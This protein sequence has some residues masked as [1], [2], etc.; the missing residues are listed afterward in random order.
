MTFFPSGNPSQAVQPLGPLFHAIGLRNLGLSSLS[1]PDIL[2]NH[3]VINFRMP[4][5]RYRPSNETINNIQILCDLQFFLPLP[6][7]RILLNSVILKH[8]NP[9]ASIAHRARG[10]W[11]TEGFRLQPV[12]DYP[13]VPLSSELGCSDLLYDLV[14]C[15]GS[16]VIASPNAFSHL[17]PSGV[18]FSLLKKEKPKK[19]RCLIKGITD[20]G[21]GSLF[22]FL[23]L[24]PPCRQSS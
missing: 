24:F 19:A 23:Q 14:C 12:A 13:E 18:C 1:I 7:C 11:G 8:A 9:R 6:Q 17:G 3:N 16:M 4:K 2:K 22:F 10:V 20:W 15:C 5:D 21:F